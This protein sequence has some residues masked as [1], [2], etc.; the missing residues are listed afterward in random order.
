MVRVCTRR[1]S[2]GTSSPAYCEK[3][4]FRLTKRHAFGAILSPKRLRARS[5]PNSQEKADLAGEG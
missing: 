1:P 3:L 2:L 5:L 4:P